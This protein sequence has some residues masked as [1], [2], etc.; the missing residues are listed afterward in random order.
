MLSL[1]R[2][3]GRVVN[4]RSALRVCLSACALLPCFAPAA[5][6]GRHWE[7]EAGLQAARMVFD[8]SEPPVGVPLS[9]FVAQGAAVWEGAHRRAVVKVGY[10]VANSRTNTSGTTRPTFGGPF[11]D[12][13]LLRM[14]SLWLP[15]HFVFERSKRLQLEFGPEW[16]YLF[17]AEREDFRVDG[18]IPAARFLVTEAFHRSA[19]AV[20]A[21]LGLE[22]PALDGHPRLT[23]RWVEGLENVAEFRVTT[24]SRP[25]AA[26]LALAW[27]R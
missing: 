26:Q 17:R 12:R 5:A 10:D 16:R 25:H 13:Q 14:Q 7:Y 1:D 18:S 9:G 6:A 15:V 23:L 22:W 4:L 3:E 8:E 21:G 24:H 2:R 11:P 27:R 19:F 20:S